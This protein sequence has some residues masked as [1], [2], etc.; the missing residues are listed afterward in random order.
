MTTFP[1]LAKV[2]QHFPR[3]ALDDVERSVDQTLTASGAAAR[4]RR[5]QRVAITAGSRGIANIRNLMRAVV[6]WV[7]A[8]GGEPFIVPAMGSH[9]GGTADG[10]AALLRDFGIDESFCGCPIRSSMETDVVCR[11]P[12]GFDVHCDR[13]AISADHVILVNRIKPHTSIAGPF[14]SGLFKML[15]IGL[16]KIPGATN[17][18]RALSEFSFEAIVRGVGADVLTK[19]KTLI[20]LAIVENAYDE[21]ALVEAILPERMLDREP[22]LLERARGWMPR[23]PFPEIDL[24]LIDRIGKNISGTGMDTNVVGRKQNDH[25]AMGDERP[26]IKRIAVRGLT[27]QTKGNAIGIGIAEFCHSRLVRAINRQSTRINCLTSAHPTGGMLPFDFESDR[28]MLATALGAIGLRRPE[29]ARLVWIA[30][31]LHLECFRC[32]ENLLSSIPAD[33]KYDI[34]DPPRELEWDASG[35][36]T[37][38]ATGERWSESPESA[39]AP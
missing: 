21:T 25:V 15:L 2:R 30:D 20:G 19:T 5:G 31:T 33:W 18:H 14:E 16:G 17:F 22:E 12:Q 6:R 13:M 39:R 36:L 32:S 35:D 7:Q 23:L 3:V 29:D 37:Q 4:I 8:A 11:A 1:R 38:T 26:Q 9:A 24:L 34:L 10:Q 27:L 28:E